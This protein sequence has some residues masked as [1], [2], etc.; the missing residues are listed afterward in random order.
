MSDLKEY[1][2]TAKT[3]SDADSIIEDMESPGG[4]LYIPNRQVSITQLR[5]LSRNTHFML[6]DEEAVQLRTDP[7]VI[8]VERPPKEM[9]I[10]VVH[11]WTQSGNFEK[12][13]TTDTNDKNW[14]LYRTVAGSTLPTWGTNGSFTQTTQTV[15]TTSSGKNVDVVVVDAHINP[16]HP[17]FAVNADG[18]GG[19]RVNRFDWF[20]LSSIVGISTTGS[21][22]Y[23]GVSGN[24]GTHVAGTVAGNTQGWARDANIY[25]M[26]FNYAGANS[27]ASWELYIFDYLRAFHLNKTVNPVTGRRNPTITNHSW[28]YSYPDLELTSITGVTYRGTFTNISALSTANKKISLEQNGVPVPGNTYLYRM[29]YTYAALNADVEDA[30][31]DGVI[32]VAAAGN[33][34]WNSAY[35]SNIDYNNTVRISGYDYIHSQGSSPAV[36]PGVIVVGNIGGTQQEYKS[37]DSNFGN[38]VDIWAPGSNIVSSVFASSAAVE[39]GI[40]L[41][42]DPRTPS[43]S[44]TYTVTNS[45]ASAYLINGSSNPTLTLYRGFTYTF[46]VSASGH[47][48]WIKTAATTGTGDAYYSGVTNNGVD[49]GTI[50]FVVPTDA[51]GTLYYICQ[52]HGTMVGTINVVSSSV[53]YLGSISGTSMAS[54]QVCGV[55]A[56]YAEQNQNLSAS[57]A[58]TYLTTHSK[59]NQIGTTGAN[60]GNYQWFGDNG[61]NQYLFYKLE[62][63]TSGQ[64]LPRNIF[65]NRPVS[66]SVYPRVNRAISFAFSGY[67]I[68]PVANNVN[69]GSSLT[70][71]VSGINTTITDGTY[72][73]TINNTTTTDAD[74]SA[75]SGSF[76]I[77]SNTGSFTISPV[78]DIT[79]EGAQTFT[80]SIRSTSISGTIVATSS[81]MTINDTSTPLYWFA[82]LGGSKASIVRSV[83]FDN[84]G[85]V[86]VCGESTVSASTNDF[87]IAKYNSSGV[88]QWQRRL[89]SNVMDEYGKSI[90]VDS[91][92]N[93]Y[94]VGH[95]YPLGSSYSRIQIAKYNS[96]GDIQ[97]QKELG[98]G[99]VSRFGT[100]IALDSSGNAYIS[101]YYSD[102]FSGTS[103][104]TA[105]YNS[106][107][108]LQWQRQLASTQGPGSSIAVD[109]LGNVYVC[110]FDS[111]TPAGGVNCYLYILKYNTSGVIQWQRRWG[112]SS[113]HIYARS[114]TVDSS[115]NV[116][117]CGEADI[118]FRNPGPNWLIVKFNSSGVAQWQRTLGE[119]TGTINKPQSITVDNLDNVYVCG[120]GGAFGSS[121]VVAKYNPSGVIQWQRALNTEYGLLGYSIKVDNS[122]NMYVCG[123]HNLPGYSG[124]TN[125][126]LIAKLPANGTG[127]GPY[128]V[129]G[130]AYSYGVSTL[131]DSN[132]LITPTNDATGSTD[133][134]VSLADAASTLIDAATTLTASTTPFTI[135][136]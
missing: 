37:S 70:V 5:E 102:G 36:A 6:S 132:A 69:E 65:K 125:D 134:A 42:N 13:S 54:P 74:F 78:A 45:G 75:V 23:S 7:R 50:T 66:G 135:T 67:S 1:I 17:E 31:A 101:G 2:V 43:L 56:C 47:P 91:A 96:L 61:N 108:I 18:T 119:S 129:N 124:Y 77:T 93:S 19:S 76:I 46:N 9:G 73:W 100:A 88:I 72:Y 68:T 55:L 114:I 94:V 86:Y 21:Y 51:P 57:E 53:Y 117:V 121:L 35:P 15:T 16:L 113:Y 33:S 109:S 12:S 49:V 133:S 34:F 118:G 27:P 24:H 10:K 80:V 136:G 63:A 38:R 28:G 116:Y 92:G 97:W 89:G 83:G 30:I 60:Y 106:S 128:T 20:T 3:M 107:G 26:E 81:S 82:Q 130:V 90:A 59:K 11:H 111:T 22:D 41:V 110:M 84:S 62:R 123:S 71:N 112:N 131:T 126:F 95:A 64:T 58:L 39:F 122:G 25:N 127:T 103:I 8:A 52:I 32:V 79:T 115:G 98:D 29:P 85:N 44:A 87:Q 104:V 99:S 4:N 48:F 14:G 105:K 120:N 40:T